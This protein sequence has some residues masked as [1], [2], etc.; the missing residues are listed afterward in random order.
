MRGGESIR[1]TFCLVSF[2]VTNVLWMLWSSSLH[3][4]RGT[5]YSSFN[6]LDA[7]PDNLSIVGCQCPNEEGVFHFL[8]Q[9]NFHVCDIA[10][11]SSGR[12][13]SPVPEVKTI[14][15]GYREMKKSSVEIC[16]LCREAENVALNISRRLYQLTS[17]FLEAHVTIIIN[18]SEDD[19]AAGLG[20]FQR[21]TGGPGARNIFFSVESYTLYAVR[22]MF[23]SR[24]FPPS[25][26]YDSASFAKRR[27]VRYDRMSILRNRCLHQVL[28]R[29][30][31]D[32]LIMNDADEEMNTDSFALHGIAHSFGLR[33]ASM[34][35]R[36]NAVCANGV[37]GVKRDRVH[38]QKMYR[39]H[40][41]PI[42]RPAWDWV[43]WDSLAYRDARFTKLS[44]REH[45]RQIHTPYDSPVEVD[46]CFGGLAV[47]DVSNST[48]WSQCSYTS[49][50]ESDCE[51]VSF[52]MCLR[53]RGWNILFNPRM[54]IT[55][56]R[57]L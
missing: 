13:A 52:S 26:I 42:P 41:E 43:F 10:C 11:T 34:T 31:T 53:R 47:Y 24:W 18:D 7:T 44:W 15:D 4:D 36:W 16:I 19:S 54:L 40:S 30:R 21:M 3:A 1:P 50:E 6:T 51:H 28:K 39:N 46:S 35:R 33:S 32:Y 2:F 22:H 57:N 45:Q 25:R 49:H 56:R 9:P 27:S 20:V 23:N 37:G 17:A 38:L 12:V 48:D 55:Y 5:P 8:A 29:P 14:M